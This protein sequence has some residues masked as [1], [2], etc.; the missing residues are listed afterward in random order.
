[1][2]VGSFTLFHKVI[3]MVSASNPLSSSLFSGQAIARVVG[4]TCIFGFIADMVALTFPLGAG[5]AWRVGLL[6]QMGDRSIVL[7]IGIA[8]L[9]YSAWESQSLRKTM[10]YLCLGAGGLFLLICLFVI[11]ESFSLH[12]QT[13]STIGSQA[14]QLQT[15]VEESRSN[16]DIAANAAP[17]DFTQAL[18][19]IETQAESLKQNARTS[20]TKVGLAS[21]S[22][23]AVVGVGLLSLGR[24]ALGPVGRAGGRSAKTTRK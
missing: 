20:I 16:P 14:S 10:S 13:V 5:T 19:A 4:L 6:Q 1:M 12:S 18:Q 7:L 3:D 15:R 22:N 23:F 21:A 9:L 8:L 24:M 2:V 17:E 11:R